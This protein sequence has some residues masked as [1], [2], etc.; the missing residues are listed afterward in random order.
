MLK[1]KRQ[2]DTEAF[3]PK[4]FVFGRQPCLALYAPTARVFPGLLP[5][6]YL[7]ALSNLVY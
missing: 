5:R 3:R 6:T 4:G 1:G 7:R 2:N